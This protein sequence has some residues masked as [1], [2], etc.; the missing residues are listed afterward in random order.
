MSEFLKQPT[1]QNRGDDERRCPLISWQEIVVCRSCGSP[2][3][4]FDVGGARR[5]NWIPGRCD[6]C[7]GVQGVKIKKN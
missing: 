3:F 4:N 2:N 5:R 6:D 7:G 1:N